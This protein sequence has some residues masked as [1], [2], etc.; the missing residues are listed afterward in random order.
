MGRYIIYRR[1]SGISKL[2]GTW[3]AGVAGEHHQAASVSLSVWV[4]KQWGHGVTAQAA[5][6]TD[7]HT[8]SDTCRLIREPRGRAASIFIGPFQH[9]SPG[10]MLQLHSADVR[11]ALNQAFAVYHGHRGRRDI[12]TRWGG[13][14]KQKNKWRKA[15]VEVKWNKMS[16]YCALRLQFA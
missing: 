1:S 3:L 15:S 12:N 8:R 7:T 4:N 13:K 10:Q 14:R 16:S 9:L 11:T 2:F 6:Y 5:C